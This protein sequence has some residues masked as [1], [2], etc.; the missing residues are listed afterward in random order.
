MK[1]DTP[2]YRS[3]GKGAYLTDSLQS[4][5]KHAKSAANGEN[6]R[7]RPLTELNLDE[8]EDEPSSAIPEK[9]VVKRKTVWHAWSARE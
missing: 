8:N 2:T 6:A 9:P 1:T 3:H 4:H 5:D 7:K